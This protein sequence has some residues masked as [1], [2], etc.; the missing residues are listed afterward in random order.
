MLIKVGL[1]FFS[2]FFI[3]NFALADL[4]GRLKLE[5][6]AFLKSQ[7]APVNQNETSLLLELES[8][9][10]LSEHWRFRFEPHLRLSSSEKIIADPIDGDFRDTQF[11]AKWGTAH[12]QLGSFIKVWEGT[13]GLNPMDIASMKN[14]RDPFS[15][16]NL[17][18]LGVAASGGEK[19]ITWD[20]IYIPQQTRSRLPGERSGWWPR[21]SSLPLQQ[22]NQILLVPDQPAY[23]FLPRDERNHALQN[24]F[25]ARLQLHGQ[26]WDFSLAGFEGAAQTPLISPAISGVLISTSPQFIVQMTNPIL[27]QAIDYRRRSSAAAF[28]YTGESWIFRTA[29]RHEESLGS[30]PILPSQY[31]QY[32]TGFE[33]TISLF[34]QNV[35]FVLQYAFGKKPQ[36]SGVLSAQNLFERAYLFGIRW[37]FNEQLLFSA[38]GFYDTVK[39]SSYQRYALQRKISDA[40]S[41]E[42][43]AEQFTGPT[44]SLLGIWSNQNRASLG[45]SF[46]F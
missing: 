6:S 4:S 42:L 34:K 21:K 3:A 32:V 27:I 24:N 13:D 15:G 25:G 40:F 22:D 45:I 1:L 10:K 5:E 8:K 38:S 11:E 33:K 28:V 9:N 41:A 37:P 43:A 2:G 17:G 14:L 18:S 20:L 7:S 35:I 16:E 31:D 26:S 36:S 19:L 30:D 29:G 12:L 23:E 39:N 46:L 44:D